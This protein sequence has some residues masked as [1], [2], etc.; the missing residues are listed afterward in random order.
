V[1]AVSVDGNPWRARPRQRLIAAPLVLDR[2]DRGWVRRRDLVGQRHMTQD[3]VGHP[4]D[5]LSDS[6]T[7]ASRSVWLGRQRNVSSGGGLNLQHLGRKA[8][9]FSD[10]EIHRLPAQNDTGVAA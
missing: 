6:C 10:H 7:E 4:L 8:R 1:L 3:D 9:W 2:I 5:P